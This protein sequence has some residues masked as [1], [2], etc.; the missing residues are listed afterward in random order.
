M[1]AG[2]SL[3]DI[4]GLVDTLGG[5]VHDEYAIID[6]RN[7]LD[8]EEGH[9]FHA[10]S[11]PLDRLESELAALVPNRHVPVI[12]IDD[13]EG[14]AHVALQRMQ[15]YGFSKVVTLDGG[16]PAWRAAELPVYSGMN[17]PSKALGA[18]VRGHHRLPTVSVDDLSDM[19]RSGSNVI[20]VDCR[21]TREFGMRAIPGSISCPGESLPVAL[22]HLAPD[23]DTLVVVTCAGRTRSVL[24]TQSLVD[25]GYGGRVASLEGGTMA[26]SLAGF[27]LVPGVKHATH[28][29]EGDLDSLSRGAAMLLAQYR[30]PCIDPDELSLWMSA[31]AST[32]IALDVRSPAA[33]RRGHLRGS[34]SA[35]GTQLLLAVDQ[36]VAVHGSRVVLIDDAH[37]LRATIAARWLRAMAID[38]YVLEGGISDVDLVGGD[39][40]ISRLGHPAAGSVAPSDVVEMIRDGWSV[41]DISLSD[42]FRGG[43]VP[44]ARWIPRGEIATSNDGSPGYIIVGDDP[45]LAALAA[46]ELS[47]DAG[48]PTA[49]LRGG[50]PA[51]RAEGFAVEVGGAGDPRDARDVWIRPSDTIHNTSSAMEAY[52]RWGDDLLAR[53]ESDPMISWLD[54]V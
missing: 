26:W 17:V 45:H 2:P 46:D 31:T 33:F 16:L 39:A 53:I 49:T 12:V 6:V 8:F 34:R 40:P 20:V 47:E 7:V 32:T 5:L 29:A 24:T 23:P 54:S 51:W 37:V 11:V 19:M 4:G 13:G 48:V 14:A 9:L 38:A 21:T 1:T 10:S 36:Y 30:I 35:P 42:R 25:V 43:H 41:I 18:A 28:D 3:I 50:M 52:L 22:A 44:G 15:R 27:D